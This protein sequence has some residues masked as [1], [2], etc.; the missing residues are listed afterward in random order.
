MRSPVLSGWLLAALLAG[1]CLA[2]RAHAAPPSDEAAPATGAI[3]FYQHYLSSLRHGHCQF[4]PSCSEYA[5][6]AIAAY[7]LVAGSA[8]AAD[9]LIRCNASAARFH[10]RGR[11]G[12]L[13]DPVGPAFAMSGGPRVPHWLLVAGE[14]PEPPVP[15]T[16]DPGR[17]AR[18]DESVAFALRLEQRG[19][20]ERASMEYQRVGSLTG[21]AETDSWSFARIGECQFAA[22]HWSAAEGAFLTSGMLAGSPSGRVTALYRAAVSSFNA[23]TYAACE[24]LM[25]DS[26]AAHESNLADRFAT[27]GG[28]CALARGGWSYSSGEL[29]RAAQLSHDDES[30]TRILGLVPFAARGQ[31]LP[32]RSAA[33]AG[34]MSAVIPGAGQVYCGRAADGS[35]HLMFNAALVWTVVSLARDHRGP[36]A[37]L[38][39]S[40]ALPFY[41]GNVLGAQATARKYDRDQR[42]NLLRD[43]IAESVR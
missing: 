15:A 17:R 25:A 2:A 22:A 18:L 21:T 10:P 30:R 6:Q 39:A 40:V 37:Y 14:P 23:G 9:R 8:R 41:L 38:T 29:R 12:R 5:A 27:L 42:M 32:H 1:V 20:C 36:A 33:I 3:R 13:D 7:G 24:R 34:T 43:A 19:D 16:L 28:L 31:A 11:D 26:S 35:R 4:D